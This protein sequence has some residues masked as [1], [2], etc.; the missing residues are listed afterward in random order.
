MAVFL[1][2]HLAKF[3][4]LLGVVLLQ[5]AGKILV[6]ARVLFFELDGEGEN[7]LFGEAVESFHNGLSPAVID[8]LIFC[9]PERGRPFPP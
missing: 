1:V 4:C 5:A 8:A 7:F 2:A 3:F 6:D 9:R